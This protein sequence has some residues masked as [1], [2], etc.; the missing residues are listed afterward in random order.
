MNEHRD[1]V[2]IYLQ[3]GDVQRRIQQDILRARNKATVTIKQAAELF[4][5]TENQLRD[6]EDRGLLT[7]ERPQ[8]ETGVK[9]RRLYGPAEI[10]KL[11]IIRE[12]R[13]AKYPPSEIPANIDQVWAT[14]ENNKQTHSSMPIIDKQVS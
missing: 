1:S 14:I 4:D 10:V 6:W 3:N 7:P 13:D 8:H 12:L 5:F 2:Q 9:G 11:A